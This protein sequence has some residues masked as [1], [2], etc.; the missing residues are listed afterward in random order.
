MREA[1]KP[2]ATT[3]KQAPRKRAGRKP[4]QKPYSLEQ[5]S[6]ALSI[7]DFCDGNVARAAQA[8]GIERK[9]LFMWRDEMRPEATQKTL[10]DGSLSIAAKLTKMAE[11]LCVIALRKAQTATIGEIRQLL[12]VILS[13]IEKLSKADRFA[14]ARAQL[15]P[16]VATQE[17]K[18]H[19]PSFDV[20]RQ[21]A[22]WEAI[23]QQ[24]MQ[25]AQSEGRP[26]TREQAIALIVESRPEAKQYLMP[27]AMPY[28]M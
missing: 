28:L 27:D 1:A 19:P 5:R 4:G 12:E 13:Q 22:H 14:A 23:V 21:K 3:K 18:T 20:E 10:A 16:A 7:L 9:T 17:P 25:Q 6:A 11:S 8:T 24:V 2:P 15:H 26:M